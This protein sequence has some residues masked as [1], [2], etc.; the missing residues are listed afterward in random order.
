MARH[1]ACND[2]I[3][4]CQYDCLRDMD[5]SSR[6]VLIRL[7]MM[8]DCVLLRFCKEELQ[9]ASCLRDTEIALNETNFGHRVKT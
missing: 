3:F 7:K 6:L 2:L 4:H 5:A 9:N 1:G 8:R